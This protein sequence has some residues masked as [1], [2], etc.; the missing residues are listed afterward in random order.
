M[1]KSFIDLLQFF[2]RGLYKVSSSAKIKS[3]E[4]PD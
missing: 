1:K 2:E 3:G 4:R